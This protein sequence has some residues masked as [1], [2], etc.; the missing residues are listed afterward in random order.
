MIFTSLQLW[1]IS[2][3]VVSALIVAFMLGRCY[4]AISIDERICVDD[5]TD[6]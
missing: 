6:E 4:E 5:D 2:A 1:F 3:G